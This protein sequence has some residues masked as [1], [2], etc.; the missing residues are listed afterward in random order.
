M[1]IESKTMVSSFL[2]GWKI[3]MLRYDIEKFKYNTM[4]T[5]N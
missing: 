4:L 3:A 2:F 1:T 5:Y